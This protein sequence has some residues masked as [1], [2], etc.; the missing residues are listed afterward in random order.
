MPTRY[1]DDL[2]AFSCIARNG[3]FTRAASELGTSTSNL[4]H[5]IKGLERQ[6]GIRLLQ[7]NSRSVSPSEAGAELLATLDPALRSVE[8]AVSTLQLGAGSVTGTLRLTATREGYHAVVR[9]VL[10]AFT[11]AHP[12]AGIEVL[13][14]YGFRDII[15]D[16][17]DAGIRLG[18][19]LEQDMIA[20][21]IGGDLRM[22]VVATP[23]YL[24][25]HGTPADPRALAAHRCINYRMVAAG[26]LYAWEFERGAE[27]LEIR[28]DG[29]LIFNQPD[30]MLDAALESLGIAY[31]LEGQAAPFIEQGRLVRLLEEWTPPFPGFF[32][33]HPS[34]QQTRPVLA[35]FVA[36]ARTLATV[37]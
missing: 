24:A 12:A 11:A 31:V 27:A 33:Y 13:I 28:V 9:P 37:I 26:S 32:L 15:S 1:L 3:S 20:I 2:A 30:L 10:P 23:A 17:F 22:A 18:E 35:A 21:K 25:K 16:R 6:L 7:R 5:T 14:E 36:L 8:S 34:R 19:K 29:P 4:S